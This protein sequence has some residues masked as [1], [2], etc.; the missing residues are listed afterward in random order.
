MAAFFVFA[1]IS[2][3]CNGLITSF[4]KEIEYSRFPEFAKQVVILNTFA[5][6]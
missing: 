6:Y 2:Y 5:L 4:L 1:K 3:F